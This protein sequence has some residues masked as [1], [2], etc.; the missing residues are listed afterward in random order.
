MTVL[1]MIQGIHS[2]ATFLRAVMIIMTNF[3]ERLHI[4]LN[5]KFMKSTSS[6]IQKFDG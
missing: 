1:V 4:T 3:T 2:D 6:Q 5:I